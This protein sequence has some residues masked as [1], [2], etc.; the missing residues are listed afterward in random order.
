M[1][2]GF[3]RSVSIDIVHIPFSRYGAY[4]ALTAE[5][6]KPYLVIRNVQSQGDACFE[7]YLLHDGRAVDYTI[8]A[9]PECI[10]CRAAEG[11][12]RLWI[13]DDET[14]AFDS[15]GIDLFFRCLD[16]KGCGSY[17][18][19]DGEESFRILE[20]SR[21]VHAL[22]TIP[23]GKAYMPGPL[24]GNSVWQWNGIPVNH[25][26][27]LQVLCEEGSALGAV[28]L[29]ALD[30]EAIPMPLEPEKEISTIRNEWEGFLAKMPPIES[31][32]NEEKE[33]NLVTWYNLWSSYIRAKGVCHYDSMVMSK[34]VM[35]NVWS[36]DHCFNALA[37][38]GVGAKEALEQFMAPFVL[39]APNGVLP[40]RWNPHMGVF[41]DFT[42]PPIHGWCFGKLMD[43]FDYSQDTL[44]TVYSCMEKQLNWWFTYR[45]E[46]H[47]GLPCYPHGNDSG[48]DNSTI[49][50][51][52]YYVTAPDLSTFLI[53]QMHTLARIA[54]KLG[55][56]KE[57]ASWKD[58]AE[59]LRQRFFALCWKGEQFAALRSHSSDYRPDPSSLQVHLPII[60]GELLGNDKIE[61]IADILKNRFLTEHGLATEA[62][63]SPRYESDGYWRGPIWAPPTY[64]IV[65]GLRSA[66]KVELAEIIARRYLRLS[67]HVAKGNYENFDAITGRGL[68]APGYTW[69]ASVYMLL[70]WEYPG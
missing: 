33:F 17:G 57:A 12:L 46:D 44:R 13:R 21:R 16:D 28:R 26:T 39:Q 35:T 8:E 63:D 25:K 19:E 69:S 51:N 49:F 65:D 43:K 34:K 67:C 47:D 20:S 31:G 24:A 58:K 56:L 27:E 70:R 53:L 41:Y 36:W 48:W 54:D 62:P 52:G 61:K 1:A 23:K 5:D 40:D 9:F 45:D 32:N 64:L 2:A 3:Y 55:M 10:C 30:P 59:T 15:R 18:I 7:L 60:L 66:G 50:D 29:S 37:M 68:R 22:F 4:V 11:M 38:A 14:I 6:G 42:K